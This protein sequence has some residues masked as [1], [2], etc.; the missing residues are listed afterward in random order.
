MIPILRHPNQ[1]G[2]KSTTAGV[3]H[4]Q[5]HL[6]GLPDASFLL[7]GFTVGHE[8]GALG[9]EQCEVECCRGSGAPVARHPPG[10]GKQGPSR[11]P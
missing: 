9:H 1:E 8:E 10:P 2:I 7:L 6:G 3:G 5:G 4:A 11:D